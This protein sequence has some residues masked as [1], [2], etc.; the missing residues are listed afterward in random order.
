MKEYKYKIN[1]NVYKVAI[2]V[3]LPNCFLLQTRWLLILP[4]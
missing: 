1:G 2:G 4:F 3:S